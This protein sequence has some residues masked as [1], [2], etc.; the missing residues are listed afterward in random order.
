AKRERRRVFP[1]LAVAATLEAKPSGDDHA[2]TGIA[3]S[4]AY[5][6]TPEN[7][8]LAK[9]AALEID[10]A[11]ATGW[12]QAR[13]DADVSR[14]GALPANRYS[15]QLMTADSREKSAIETFLRAAS[16]ELNADRIMVYPAGTRENPRVSVLYGNYVERADA[17]E[18][19]LRLPARL[20]K[21][22]PYVRSVGAIREDLRPLGG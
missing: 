20:T 4:V 21:F 13:M 7:A 8:A 16:R 5:Q 22:R 1:S 6:A 15:I 14:L 18:E 3:N 17:S 12:L 19:M 2:K 10:A 11:A 9:P